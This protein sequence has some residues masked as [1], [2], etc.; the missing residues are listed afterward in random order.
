MTYQEFLRAIEKLNLKWSHYQHA[1]GARHRFIR[2]EENGD[3]PL[4]ALQR[5][6]GLGRRY[7]DV[8]RAGKALHLSPLVAK[9]IADMAD[10]KSRLSSRSFLRALRLK[11]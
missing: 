4:V 2:C 7:W 5:A 1:P 3:C 6:M 10:G 9:K 11:P 8:Y